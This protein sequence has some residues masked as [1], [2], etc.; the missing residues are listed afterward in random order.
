[1]TVDS[2]Y[3]TLILDYGVVGLLLYAWSLA[4]GIAVAIRLT[5]ERVDKDREAGLI[6]PATISLANFVV[7]KTV[8]S[9]SDNHPLIYM[10]LGL[11]T[12]LAYRSQCA[13]TQAEPVSC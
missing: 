8:F 3:L 13:L 12:A 10:L 7:I 1:V 2:Y 9:Q 5:F 11:V 4:V 6:L